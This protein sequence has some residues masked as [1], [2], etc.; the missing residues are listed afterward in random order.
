MAKI[1]HIAYR[2]QDMEA[3]A[4][5]FCEAF[6]MTI[7]QRRGRGA[8]DLTDGTLN[9][10]LLP[11]GGPGDT[12]IK[13][14]E[15]IG[16]SAVDDEAAK[17][18]ILAAGGREKNTVHLGSDVHFEVKYEGPEGIVVDIGHWAGTAPVNEEEEAAIPAGSR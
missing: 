10:T 9:I 17:R 14:I 8:I 15:H 1:R 5:F 6:D 18:K 12:G 11:A 3:M 4:R 7:A 16:F 2:A 13:G